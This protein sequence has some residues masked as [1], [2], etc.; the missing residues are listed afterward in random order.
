[1]KADFTR[2]TFHPGKHF[3]RVLLQQ[4]RV[5][6]DADW[7]EQAAILLHY[8]QTL[9]AD[10]IGPRGG[11]ADRCGFVVS[12]LTASK[13]VLNDFRIANGRYYVDGILCELDAEAIAVAP[14]PA[15]QPKQV[16]V[17]AWTVDG[18]EFAR[19]QYVELADAA[20]PPQTK[21]AQIVDVDRTASTLMLDVDIS[22][23][24]PSR[25]R[26]V[27]TYLTQPH[28][29]GAEPLAAGD[30]FA[31]LD[32][33]ERVVTSVEDDSIREVALNGADTA[34]RTKIVCHVKVIPPMPGVTDPTTLLDPPNRG[35]LRARSAK[36]GAST[37]PCTI[38][39]NSKYR[40]PENQLYRVEV[41]TGSLD[42][43]GN[44]LTP[45]FKWSRENGAPVFAIARAGGTGAFVLEHL[46]RD[47]RF[48]LLEGDWVEIQDDASVL[49][50]RAEPLLQVESIDR[51]SRTVRLSGGTGSNTGRTAGLHPLLRRWEQKA[52]DPVEGG[53]ELGPDHAALIVEGEWLE[54]E[55]GVQI[56]FAAPVAGQPDPVYRTGDYWEIPAR[57][58]LGDVIWPMGSPIDE[59]D[60]TPV[61]LAQPPA[62]ITHHY[63][64]L[65]DL[66]IDAT[67]VTVTPRTDEFSPLP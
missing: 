38:S 66:T 14:G 11:P 56:Q 43:A 19:D 42:T 4:G 1:M 62:G 50:N 5:Q 61:P 24:N 59:Q 13:P 53:L 2:S 17:S 49:L 30:H 51:V 55:H 29:A 64:P 60:P 3:A 26:R 23:L 27:A 37:D 33:W 18:V 39:P 40:G 47:D 52:G 45:T 63:A 36:Q 65:A 67:T 54:L 22:A 20:T 31:Y 9:A 44:P 48:G 25:L 8:L 58:T 12:S 6:L 41:H 46:G 21:V 32:V 57:V 28:F 16:V 35:F 34:A 7:N 15:S 10:I